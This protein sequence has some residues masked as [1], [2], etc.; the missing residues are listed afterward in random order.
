MVVR[1]LLL[2]MGLF[3]N[4]SYEE[5]DILSCGEKRDI[6]PRTRA[7]VIVLEASR[8]KLTTKNLLTGYTQTIPMMPVNNAPEKGAKFI[9]Y[10]LSEKRD[11]EWE[12]V[13][14]Y[15]HKETAKEQG[16]DT[17][18]Q[19]IEAIVFEVTEDYKE[20]LKQLKHYPEKFR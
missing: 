1:F 12:V 7:I 13:G 19:K 4:N 9:A 3:Q 10:E 8:N 20:H 5:G 6:E 2:F 17:V 18:E 16:D 11:G 14:R 15:N